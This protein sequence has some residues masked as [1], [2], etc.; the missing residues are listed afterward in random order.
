ME[1]KQGLTTLGQIAYG[2]LRFLN[3][4]QGEVERLSGLS[5]QEE[6][7]R[8]LHA[9]HRAVLQMSELY[10]RALDQ[11]GAENASIFMVHNMLLEDTDFLDDV[12]ARI[13]RGETA[14]WALT[15]VADEIVDTFSK[16]E[17]AYMQARA[18]DV[19]DICRR[20]FNILRGRCCHDPLQDEAAIL[21]VDE[22]MPSQVMDLRRPR[23]LGVVSQRGSLD[24]HSA[25]LLEAYHIPAIAGVNLNRSWDGHLALIDG[26]G[27]RLYLEPSWEVREELRKRYEQGGRV[28]HAACG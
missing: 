16:I 8:F 4:E 18:A 20:L 17:S 13:D 28:S 24:S 21:V 27:Q 10:Q 1:I 5:V 14:E 7:E 11:V 12:L 2:R 25:M 26:I 19:K 15:Q 9:Q 6:R 22:F 23:L 3:W